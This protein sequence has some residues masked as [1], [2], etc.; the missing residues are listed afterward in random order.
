M[1]G[2]SVFLDTVAGNPQITQ[3]VQLFRMPLLLTVLDEEFKKYGDEVWNNEDSVRD[4]ARKVMPGT[5]SQ[6]GFSGEEADRVTDLCV[7]DF[8][9]VSAER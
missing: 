2:R 6:F 3:G 8:I 7:D 5:L 4:T 1:S 9:K